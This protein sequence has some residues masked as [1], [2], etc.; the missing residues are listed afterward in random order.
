MELT[1]ILKKGLQARKRGLY[2]P[3]LY[4]RV[5]SVGPELRLRS[6]TDFG[7]GWYEAHPEISTYT[8]DGNGKF[9]GRVL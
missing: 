4:A 2:K 3:P 8:S 1:P 5:A 7:A 9:S 6:P